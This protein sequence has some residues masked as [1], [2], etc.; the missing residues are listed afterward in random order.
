LRGENASPKVIVR[1]GDAW[2]TCRFLCLCRR[3]RSGC[4]CPWRR[5]YFGRRPYFE[6]AAETLGSWR[7]PGLFFEED[8]FD[9]L[10]IG[11]A[12]RMIHLVLHSF[13][14][15]GLRWF[16]ACCSTTK[17]P[18]AKAVASAICFEPKSIVVS[19]LFQ[20]MVVRSAGVNGWG[21][22]SLAV[23]KQWKFV[24]RWKRAAGSCGPLAC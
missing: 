4:C 8:N 9:G 24:E 23:G 10:G 14:L 18:N 12:G 1:M 2:P 3:M 15:L 21:C 22:S 11:F 20:T 17:S 16:G 5:R 7:V 13:P 19:R 6:G